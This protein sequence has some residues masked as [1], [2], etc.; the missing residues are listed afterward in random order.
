[1]LHGPR[2]RFRLRSGLLAAAVG[3]ALA[4]C[5]ETVPHPKVQTPPEEGR[6]TFRDRQAIVD[7][8]TRTTDL[9]TLR[10]D[11]GDPLPGDLVGPVEVNDM[12]LSDVLRLV[13]RAHRMP[14]VLTGDAD[15]E[16]V[17]LSIP[18]QLP[19]ARVVHL[20]AKQ[21]GVFYAYS[22]GV[23][24]IDAE[25]K[26]SLRVPNVIQQ[27]RYKDLTEIQLEDGDGDGGGGG[28]GDGRI[29]PIDPNQV[30]STVDAFA[31]TLESLGG[32][33]VSANNQ[34]G[35]ITFTA[36]WQT[37][38][39]VLDFLA[40]YEESRQLLVYDVWLYEV[41]LNNA[42]RA[43]INWAALNEE[44]GD[45]TIGGASTPIE[46]APGGLSDIGEGLQGV[47]SGVTIGL[48]GAPGD[49]VLGAIFNFLSSQ[50]E[51]KTL[52]QPTISVIAG[53]ESGVFV[54]EK[55]RFIKEVSVT[56]EDDDDGDETTADPDTAALETGLR[57]GMTGDVTNGIVETDI[58][59]SFVELLDLQEVRM[60][61]TLMQLP[62]TAERSLYTSVRARPG[63]VIVLGG[64]IYDRG[65][66]DQ[67]RLLLADMPLRA[68][69][70]GERAE[71]VMLMRPRLVRFHSPEGAADKTYGEPP[72]VVGRRTL[73]DS[74]TVSPSPVRTP[75]TPEA[76]RLRRGATTEQGIVDGVKADADASSL[77]EEA[78]DALF[79]AS[80]VPLPAPPAMNRPAT[81]PAS[82][83]ASK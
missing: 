75:E 6:V 4:G 72:L 11:R 83:A 82:G 41:T 73:P 60:G 74:Q 62:H 52:A 69:A 29:E 8:E 61:D 16:T 49:W 47:G 25:R 24:R 7:L 70:Q 58:N 54:G 50:G 30:F 37:Y 57:L 45:F 33:D 63:D 78:R 12:P 10:H 81:E 55:M 38:R 77:V 71:L 76:F 36:D 43:G 9:L 3:L 32:A 26:F 40:T 15:E 34:T 79:S 67:D 17:S 42:R 66:R 44:I 56:E 14:V 64:L 28:G 23:L 5:A 19:L 18:G 65:A 39:N 48:G 13:T 31:Q 21:A 27:S 46:I 53:R 2:T 20:L 1:M 35:I 59:L 22:D 80:P 68:N 51:A